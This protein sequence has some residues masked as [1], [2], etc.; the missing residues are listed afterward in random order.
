MHYLGMCCIAKDEDPF[1]KEW[2]AYHAM[3]GVERFYIYDNCSQ[4]PIKRLLGE[5]AGHD[6]VVV[7][8]V[9]GRRM[10]LPVY[11]DCLKSFGAECRWLA[12][13]DL[14]EF[15]CPMQDDDLR[16]LL[17]E[18]EPYAGLAATWR[19]FNS[20]GHLKRPEGLALRNYTQAFAQQ[21]SFAVKCIVDPARTAQ[22]LSPHHFRHSPGECCVNED[23]Y[24]FAPGT[25][26]SFSPGRLVRVNH[27]FL[28]SQQDYEEKMRR[29][30]GATRAEDEYRKMDLFL[31]A[32]EKPQ[33]EDKAI[34]RF[35]PRLEKALKAPALPMPQPFLPTG[36]A[37][38]DIMRAAMG[39]LEAGQAEKAQACL[40]PARPEH[41]E[42]A[43]LWTLRAL[44]AQ[45]AG[46]TGR[47]EVFIKEALKREATHAAYN[48]LKSLLEQKGLHEQAHGIEVMLRSY[49]EFFG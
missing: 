18:F 35:L 47:A 8:R 21:E 43:D 23:H 28:R 14:D 25:H 29:G 34:Q 31:G 33:V 48:I 3:L 32:L 26:F 12:F 16:P 42:K 27:Y 24:P 10:Q 44:A 19:L 36:T 7:R 22:A 30:G 9:E 37:Y 13:I 11:D 17:A 2:L 38:E 6:R 4:T 45:S 49:P 1:L 40:C 41:R 46:K 20:S 39:F 5:Y 15:I